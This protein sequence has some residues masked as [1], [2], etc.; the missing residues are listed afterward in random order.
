MRCIS[1]WWTILK[2][3]LVLSLHNTNILPDQNK[4]ATKKY[5]HCNILLNYVKLCAQKW[6][7]AVI[8]V[9]ISFCNFTK[10]V[11]IQCCIIFLFLDSLINDFLKADVQSQSLKFPCVPYSVRMEIFLFTNKQPIV[12]FLFD[13]T[14]RLSVCSFFSPPQ[15][16][17][18]DDGSPLFFQ[19]FSSWTDLI[20][21]L[22]VFA[23]SSD[24]F[25]A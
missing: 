13:F 1:Q 6:T 25:P 4:V 3:T 7:C 9:S 16:L 14:K 17:F 5:T 8:I 18:E 10:F 12:V 23:I 11:L 15:L 22:V 20:L 24:V 19:F 2:H 21:I